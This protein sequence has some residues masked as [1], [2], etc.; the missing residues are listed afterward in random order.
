M[1]AWYVLNSLGFY[2]VTPG[3]GNF[4]FGTA[5]FTEAKIHLENGKI[6][7]ISK[8]NSTSK[9]QYIQSSS[10]NGKLSN[11]SVLS[12][13]TIV[14]GG[15]LEFVMQE[16]LDEKNLFGKSVLLRPSTNITA[17]QILQVPVIVTPAKLT[18]T[19]KQLA[20]NILTLK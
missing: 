13:S 5:G 17:K 15:K 6:F 1:S 12:H 14:A 10:I 16:K 7:E 2:S 19:K 11:S 9:F 3:G 20:L 8:K 4:M 18:D